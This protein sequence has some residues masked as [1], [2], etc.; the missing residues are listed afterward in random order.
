MSP[1]LENAPPGSSARDVI[2]FQQAL[3][4]CSDA[5][6][7]LRRDLPSIRREISATQNRLKDL[8]RDFREMRATLPGRADVRQVPVAT[9]AT[10]VVHLHRGENDSAMREYAGKVGGTVV[11]EA[12]ERCGSCGH[13]SGWF[14]RK[15]GRH[16]C[17]VC[18][19]KGVRF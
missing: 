17:Q 15:G 1:K 16:L 11:C 3:N 7:A 9:R 18:F 19:A 4:A 10:S 8:E 14:V 2:W 12:D 5:I 6:T 13:K